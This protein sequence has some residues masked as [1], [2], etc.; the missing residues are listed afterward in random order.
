M[1]LWRMVVNSDSEVKYTLMQP[2]AKG[3]NSINLHTYYQMKL[4]SAVFV[5]FLMLSFSMIGFAVG[6]ELNSPLITVCGIGGIMLSG[7]V[8]MMNL[9]HLS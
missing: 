7:F 5:L 8:Y 3:L 2:L 4:Y 9:E 1:L 6:A